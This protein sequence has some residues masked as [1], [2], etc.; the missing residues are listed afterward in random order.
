[1]LR[2]LRPWF[3]TTL[4]QNT[5]RRLTCAPPEP[6]CR[7]GSFGCT[8]AEEWWTMPW[9]HLQSICPEQTEMVDCERQNSLLSKKGSTR[10][11]PGWFT[12]KMPNL[13]PMAIKLEHNHTGKMTT[14]MYSGW[15]V[16]NRHIISKKLLIWCGGNNNIC[17]IGSG[18]GGGWWRRPP[19]LLGNLMHLSSAPV[20]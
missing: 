4:L 17:I 6:Q 19:F 8:F 5:A 9:M 3:A 2:L 10:D 13:T 11:Y 18:G 16:I 12:N 20:T 7:I 15:R 14:H 1:M